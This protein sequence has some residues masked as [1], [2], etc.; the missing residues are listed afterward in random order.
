MNG[1]KKVTSGPAS[2]SN[3]NGIGIFRVYARHAEVKGG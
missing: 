1:M 2:F 3:E